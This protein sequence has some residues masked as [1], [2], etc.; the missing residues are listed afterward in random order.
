[1][2]RYQSAAVAAIMLLAVMTGLTGCQGNG[3]AER[4]KQAQSDTGPERVSVQQVKEW[5]SEGDE[6]V[7]LDSRSAAAWASGDT[8]A[9]GAI[10]VPPNDVAGYL[11]SIP[12]DGKIIVY[13]T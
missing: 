9:L 7:I 8:K 4:T 2:N 6:L 1:M 10:R 13:C 3:A 12:A 11:E 5:M